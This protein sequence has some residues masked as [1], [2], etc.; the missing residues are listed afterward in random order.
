MSNKEKI[1]YDEIDLIQLFFDILSFRK[2]IIASLLFSI[3]IGT[4]FIS[5]SFE[6]YQS[7]ATLFFKDEESDPTS[8]ISDKDYSFLFENSIQVQDQVS[9]IS[10]SLIL[11]NVVDNLNLE[12]R[13]YIN[14]KLKSNYELSDEELPFSI[15]FKENFD[16]DQCFIKINNQNIVFDINGKKISFPNTQKEIENSI[17]K[18]K[19][20]EDLNYLEHN[21]YI[22][23]YVKKTKRVSQ[24]KSNYSV[25]INSRQSNSTYEISYSGNNKNL[26][27]LI[28]ENIIKEILENNINEKRKLYDLSIEFIEKRLIELENTI[29][30]INILSSD[31]K[32]SNN[33]FEPEAQ[34]YSVLT[35]LEEINQTLFSNSLQIELANSIINELNKPKIMSLL[36]TNIG[37]ESDNINLLINQF[38]RIIIEQNNLLNDATEKNPLYIQFQEQLT[39]IKINILKSLELYIN[40]LK[41]TSKRFED[42]KKRN[43][44]LAD[45]LPLKVAELNNLN[46]DN[47]V[48]S[49]LYSYLSEK[50]EEALMNRS[51]IQSNIIVLNNVGY[52]EEVISLPIT[53]NLLIFSLAGLILP[54]GI[55]LGIKY[56]RKSLFVDIKYLSENLNEINFFG[57]LKF[58]DLKNKESNSLFLESL[59][60]ISHNLTKTIPKSK[61]GKSIMITSCYKNEGKTYASSNISI[62]L[63]NLGY[64]VILVGGDLRNP[65]LGKNFDFDSFNFPGLTDII[66]N[67]TKSFDELLNKF[68]IK[69]EKLDIL[70]SG[71]QKDGN[72]NYFSNKRFNHLVSFLKQKYDYIVFDTAPIIP[73]V[74]T[75]D[76]L[77]SLDFVIHTFR[78]N[79][80]NRKYCDVVLNYKKKYKLDE[81]AYILIDDSKTDK[82]ISNYGYGYGGYGYGGYGY[83]GYGYGGYGNGNGKNKI[84]INH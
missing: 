62:Q 8:F 27:T 16:F 56:F 26:N 31:F 66:D 70:N 3:I 46:R 17:F 13:Y 75:L 29:D 50:K 19:A 22:I 37:L 36:P 81:F 53:S 28:L 12:N 11:G 7:N 49:N 82:L 43:N 65:D 30:S 64:K 39:E 59:R 57:V 5:S 47:L 80:S 4:I 51:S 20:K 6:I 48:Y 10:S 60:I 68:L 21:N 35:N 25:S 61:S 34:T 33:I 69:Y 77:D 9:L 32:R 52:K 67:K 45:D 2:W 24:L 72:M 18:F 74:D 1:E 73:V 63:S 79:F 40:K 44:F 54:I 42:D 41:T 23:E 15:E 76:L 55:G 83:G 71:L 84:T 78:N 58:I 38:N 14:N